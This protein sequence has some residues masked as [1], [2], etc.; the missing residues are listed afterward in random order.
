MVLFLSTTP[1]DRIRS[2]RIRLIYPNGA[3]DYDA[4]MI[5]KKIIHTV[6]S[7]LVVFAAFA[8]PALAQTPGAPPDAVGS[9]Y[10]KS[11]HGAWEVRCIR[12]ENGRERCQMF[13]QINQADG[14]PV[15]EINVFALNPGQAAAAG[16]II[17]TPLETL[18]TSELRLT[19]DGAAGK[20]YPFSWCTDAG[21]VVRI[22]LTAEELKRF[23]SG[24]QATAIIV[25]VA[26]PDTPVNLAVSLQGFTAGF[27]AMKT[28]NATP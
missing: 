24:I 20:R 21:C 23:Q 9:T 5:N 15:A 3:R 1:P 28:A 2:C 17:V 14:N 7:A 27:N 13:Q 11:T 6:F 4:A 16:A 22:G 12:I 26:S 10:V 25:P 8:S 18:L 19:V